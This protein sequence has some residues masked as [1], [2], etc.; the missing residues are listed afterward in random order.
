M[1]PCTPRD[2]IPEQESFYFL[3]LPCCDHFAS[4]R[5]IFR[6]SVGHRQEHSWCMQCSFFTLQNSACQMVPQGND[7][8]NR[9]LSSFMFWYLFLVRMLCPVLPPL[10]LC[11]KQLSQESFYNMV[12]QSPFLSVI[13][14]IAHHR[15]MS[16]HKKLW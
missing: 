9:G 5:M 7:I 15:V 10:H 11:K 3:L 2:L 8:I 4:I 13:M 16:K 12:Y 6:E 1:S 14:L